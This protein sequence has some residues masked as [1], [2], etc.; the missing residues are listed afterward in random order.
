M[1]IDHI[2][3]A[4]RNLEEGIAYWQD[5]FGY[6]QMTRPVTNTR[7]KVKVVFLDKEDSLTVKLIEPL[8]DN[9]SLIRFIGQ[10]GGFHHLCFRCKDLNTQL[11]EL[12]EKGLRVLVPP[13]PGEAFNMQHIAFLWGKNKLNFELIDT[14][15]KAEKIG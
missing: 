14:E 3:F 15:E 5:I 8:A 12:K 13:Q 4:V 9:P 11:G 7:Q 6:S 1:I 2:C 10:G